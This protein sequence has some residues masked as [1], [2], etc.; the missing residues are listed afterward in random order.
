MLACFLRLRTKKTM[1]PIRPASTAKPPIAP[2]T[3]A[4][5]GVLG[6]VGSVSDGGGGA[7]SVGGKEGVVLSVMLVVFVVGVSLVM[8]GLNTKLCGG[9]ATMPKLA[10]ASAEFKTVQSPTD[11]CPSYVVRSVLTGVARVLWQISMAMLSPG[12]VCRWQ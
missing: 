5:T 4:P 10:D 7:G 9:K 11:P 8:I 3:M 6:S 2:P 12:T 1:K